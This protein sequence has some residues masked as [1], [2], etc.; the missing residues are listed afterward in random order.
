MPGPVP[1]SWPGLIGYEVTAAVQIIN[2]ERPDVTIVRVLPPSEPPSPPPQDRVRV[3]I[4]N[5][6]GRTRNTFVVV[7]PAPFIG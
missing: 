6:I 5:D 1:E 3:V 4:Y 7:P 2:R